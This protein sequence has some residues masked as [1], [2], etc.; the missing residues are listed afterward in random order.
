MTKPNLKHGVISLKEQ[1]PL[2]SGEKPTKSS[3]NPRDNSKVNK[4][5]G[6]KK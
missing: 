5:M 2:K 3:E 1:T 6:E 4:V